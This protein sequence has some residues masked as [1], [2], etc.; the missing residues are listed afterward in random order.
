MS[1]RH[2]KNS[3]KSNAERQ[4]EVDRQLELMK[5]AIGDDNFDSDSESD[6]DDSLEQLKERSGS[7]SRNAVE[8]ARK[9]LWD[10]ADDEDDAVLLGGPFPTKSSHHHKPLWDSSHRSQLDD[11]INLHN[12]AALGGAAA[13]EGKIRQSFSDIFLRGNNL[14]NRASTTTTTTGN[15]NK[16]LKTT[17]ATWYDADSRDAD[18]ALDRKVKPKSVWSYLTCLWNLVLWFI[19]LSVV[20]VFGYYIYDFAK[21]LK[22]EKSVEI[23]VTDLEKHA[24]AVQKA[25]TKNGVLIE[26]ALRD[27]DS[28]QAAALQWLSQDTFETSTKAKDPYLA[29]RYSLAVIYHATNGMHWANSDGWL[30]NAGYCEWYGVQ[31]LGA[32][33]DITSHH[34]NGP[35]FELNLSSNQ[36]KGTIPV[37]LNALEAL[38][39]LDLQDNAIEGTIPEELGGW[40]ALRM[41]S[42]AHNELYGSIPV[43]LLTTSPDLHVL[44]AGHNGFTGTIPPELGTATKLREIRLEY[45]SLYGHIPDS[46]RDLD[47]VETLHLAGNKLGG[48]L[49]I[50]IYDMARLE[51]LH[52]HDNSLTGHL[53]NN[54]ASLSHLE[55]LTLN[56]NQ[57]VGT[58][59]NV[60]SNA[61]Y[62][63]EIQLHANEL[64]GTMPHSV[65]SLATER[66]LA[67]LSATCTQTNVEGELGVHCDCCTECK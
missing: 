47:R 58:I 46:V 36:V 57:L 9:F 62:L 40:S 53:S 5:A 15:N 14:N 25:L 41:F 49:P 30:T 56:H 3:K 7:S 38:F 44:N 22:P 59:P 11:S 65:C 16:K 51:T 20:F 66:K 67:Y 8:S 21:S 54:F 52:L 61:K 34:G 33:T 48:S 28:P 2:S 1:E 63:Q 18:D 13:A 17:A 55:L 64:S 12:A 19:L 31:C 27:A 35:V 10:E 60:F 6:S 26:E 4:R 29:Q 32:E 23:D 39:F 50:G 42:I 24:S 37:E 43:T 45:N